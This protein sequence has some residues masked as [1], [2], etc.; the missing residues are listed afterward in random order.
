M[1]YLL[2]EATGL[3]TFQIENNRTATHDK[4]LRPKFAHDFYFRVM[5][6]KFYWKREST[7]S[8]LLLQVSGQEIQ[9]RKLVIAIWDDDSGKSHD[10]YME[11]ITFSMKEFA[12]FEKL[13]KNVKVTLKHQ[14]H[15][16]HVE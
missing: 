3:S 6:K 8:Y 10:D 5:L 1:V 14:H 4:Q 9:K 13:G 11:G 12:Y 15:D 16:G 7:L 2:N